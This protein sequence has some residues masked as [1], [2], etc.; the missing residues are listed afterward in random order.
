MGGGCRC[1][2]PEPAPTLVALGLALRRD[3]AGLL[4]AG[5]TVAMLRDALPLY[6]RQFLAD[7]LGLLG[8]GVPPGEVTVP[9]LLAA[10]DRVGVGGDD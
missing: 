5:A 4:L 8:G 10:L 3:E 2:G 9:R 7:F 1:S 6:Y